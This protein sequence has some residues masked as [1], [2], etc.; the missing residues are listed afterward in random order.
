[1]EYRES[2]GIKRLLTNELVPPSVLSVASL[3]IVGFFGP[4]SHRPSEL[5]SNS[6]QEVSVGQPIVVTANI[7]NEFPERIYDFERMMKKIK[8]A[9]ALLQE[10][11]QG[12]MPILQNRFRGWSIV[13][14]NGDTQGKPFSSGFG[15]VI[16]SES[17]IYEHKSVNL[18]QPFLVEN[19]ALALAKTKMSIDGNV[20]TIQ[21]ATGHIGRQPKLRPAQ[22][23]LLVKEL[24][25]NSKDGEST[26]FCGDMNTGTATTRK[27][28]ARGKFSVFSPMSATYIGSQNGAI[29]D[30][31]AFYAGGPIGTTRVTEVP[32][33]KT[34]HVTQKIRLVDYTTLSPLR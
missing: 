32:E 10:V 18:D 21:L 30:H 29:V 27:A 1:M 15:N 5:I 28:F 8:P 33:F 4:N 2:G 13:F 9:A 17:R 7:H 6:S 19:R 31:C 12:S 34:D 24:E 22:L 14:Y 20:H 16:M 25:N 26:V 11:D 3:A 23:E